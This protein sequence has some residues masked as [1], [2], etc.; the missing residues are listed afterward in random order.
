MK[1]EITVTREEVSAL[2]KAYFNCPSRQLK[3]FIFKLNINLAKKIA[4]EYFQ[5]SNNNYEDLFQ[6]ASLGLISAIDRYDPAYNSSFSTYATSIIQGK[7]LQYIRDKGSLIRIPQCIQDNYTKTKKIARRVVREENRQ[8]THKEIAELSGIE[9]NE[10]Q[11]IITTRSAGFIKN[12]D[13]SIEEVPSLSTVNAIKED[14][15]MPINI[16]NRRESWEKFANKK[17]DW[18]N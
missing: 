5:K 1:I 11:E 12:L 2:L 13:S 3:D 8:P 17:T 15:T 18:K 9:L 14:F 6:E 10:Y 4:N 16:L 7:I